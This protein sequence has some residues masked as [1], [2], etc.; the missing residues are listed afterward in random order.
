MYASIAA[1]L[2]A[3]LSR[4]NVTIR[5]ADTNDLPVINPNILTSPTDQQVAVASYKRIRQMF[6]SSEMAPVLI[7]EEYFP[8]S[9]VQTD[10]ELLENIKE[11]GVAYYHAG[12]SCA[13]GNPNV[14]DSKAVVDAKARV[15]GVNGLRV[16][17]ASYVLTLL[18]Q[19]SRRCSDIDDRLLEPCHF[20][21][22]ATSKA[23]SVS[24]GPH[25]LYCSDTDWHEMPW[26]RRSRMR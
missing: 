26:P 9:S 21:L 10:E 16:V 2:V 23:Q 25:V 13:M 22:Q 6:Q 15:I 5:S 3:P 8:G 18:M 4:G 20:C 14:P 11:N 24:Y 1:A 17:D 12:G 7:G 19:R